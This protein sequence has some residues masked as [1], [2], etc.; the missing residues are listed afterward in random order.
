MVN[1]LRNS[2]YFSY[3][4]A[5]FLAVVPASA[6]SCAQ[7]SAP[8]S[9]IAVQEL[10]VQASDLPALQSEDMYAIDGDSGV[11]DFGRLGVN[12]RRFLKNYVVDIAEAN[13]ER[14]DNLAEVR[15]ALLPAIALLT[16]DFAADRPSNELALTTGA[17]KSIWDDS[18]DIEPPPP[19][20]IDRNNIY[21]VVEDGFYYNV[22]NQSFPSPD[23]T[24]TD[25]QYFLKGVYTI[26]R[27]ATEENAGQLALN[28]IDL[29]FADS[30]FRLG[31]LPEGSDLRQLVGEIEQWVSEGQGVG[32]P[33]LPAPGPA[34]QT[35]K[36]FNLY[37]DAD[38]RIAAGIDGE[39]PERTL[40][41]FVL[42]RVNTVGD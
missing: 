17:W 40:G 1:Q 9:E 5:A 35:G 30:V 12:F 16:I 38:L 18:N 29:E 4:G 8:P 26:A 22:T 3:V 21:Q 7:Q 36:L 34:G 10:L 6:L 14:R 37:V 23:G 19:L 11:D 32:A 13:T 24:L 33:P 25:T 27:P 20:T 39:D 31:R 15:R 2:T 42:T 41:L 28:I